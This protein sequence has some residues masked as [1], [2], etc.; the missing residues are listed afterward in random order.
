M[1]RQA[2]A[3]AAACG[4]AALGAGAAS[5][6]TARVSVATAHRGTVLM[7]IGTGFAPPIEFCTPLAMRVDGKAARGVGRL[8]DDYGGYAIRVAVPRALGL[9]RIELRQT[10]ENGNTGARRL[11]RATARFRVIA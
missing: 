1:I 5:A 6:A 2:A 3:L 10:C 4:L 9:H 8:I 11:A 7:V